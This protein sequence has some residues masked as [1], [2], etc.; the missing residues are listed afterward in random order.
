[1]KRPGVAPLDVERN[2]LRVVKF[3]HRGHVFEDGRVV[4]DGSRENLPAGGHIERSYP[5]R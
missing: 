1:M 4:F 3:S 2:V 5:G